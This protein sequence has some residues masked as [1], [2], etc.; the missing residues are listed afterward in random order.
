MLW[1]KAQLRAY[2]LWEILVYIQ[3]YIVSNRHSIFFLLSFPCITIHTLPFNIDICKLQKSFLR[4]L[5]Y[6]ARSYLTKI[7]LPRRTRYLNGITWIFQ[8]ETE[9]RCMNLELNTHSISFRP[10]KFP[11]K[12]DQY[13]TTLIFFKYQFCFSFESTISICR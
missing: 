1:N 10:L 7:D 11:Y 12:Y 3:I 2:F 8:I 6:P 13:K 4:I 9:V 5:I